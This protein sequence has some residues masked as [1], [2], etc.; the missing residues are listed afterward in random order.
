MWINV[1]G[2]S[3][4]V[5]VVEANCKKKLLILELRIHFENDRNQLHSA[6]VRTHSQGGPSPPKFSYFKITNSVG[7]KRFF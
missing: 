6:V 7:L 3:L 5:L 4:V 1:V 2:E